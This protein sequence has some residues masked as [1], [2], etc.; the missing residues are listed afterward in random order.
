MK[1][2]ITKTYEQQRD[3]FKPAIYIIHVA[4]WIILINH[5]CGA[6]TG[7]NTMRNIGLFWATINIDVANNSK[8]T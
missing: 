6:T 3:L 4:G 7:I 8:D 1:S 5:V 2:W